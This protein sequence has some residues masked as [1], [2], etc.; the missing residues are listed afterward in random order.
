MLFTVC[1]GYIVTG[2]AVARFAAD[3][4]ALGI[5]LAH[6]LGFGFG[7]FVAGYCAFDLAGFHF[8]KI[9]IVLTGLVD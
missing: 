6:N 7:G 3:H 1:A 4:T 5:V 9:Y 8:P 2:F